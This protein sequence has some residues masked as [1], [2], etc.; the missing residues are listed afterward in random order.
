ML[1]SRSASKDSLSSGST[2]TEQEVARLLLRIGAVS[3]NVATPYIYSSGMKSPIYCDNRLIISFPEERRAVV[4]FL[5]ALLE[6]AAGTDHFDVVA[7]V[8]TA[9][10]P[11]ASWLAEL[12]QK[13]LIYIRE[14]SKSHGKMLQVEGLLQPGK[15]VVVIEDLITTGRSALATIGAVREAGG[16]VDYC[17]ALFTYE[18]N[19]A[20]TA[21]REAGVQLLTLCRISAVLQVATASG[22]I[23]PDE[24]AE[25]ERWLHTFHTL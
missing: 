8:A 9:G 2:N 24:K 10:I 17:A 7:G 21:F 4:G 11:F 20:L 25:V 13:P 6:N 1:N 19:S 3:I 12:L 23:S 5:V 15:R 16:V 18:S 14:T 22:K